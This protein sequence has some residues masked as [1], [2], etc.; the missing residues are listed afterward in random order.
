MSPDCHRR[1]ALRLTL[2]FLPPSTWSPARN[3]SAPLESPSQTFGL[4]GRLSLGLSQT[5]VEPAKQDRFDLALRRK[6]GDF[7][8]ACSCFQVMGRYPI[9]IVPM[10]AMLTLKLVPTRGMAGIRA[11]LGQLA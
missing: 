4:L 8:V 5:G 9:R 3:R 6:K 10:S 1:F 2:G 7:R 11:K